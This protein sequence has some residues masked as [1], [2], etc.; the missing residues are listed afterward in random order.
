M[1]DDE[2]RGRQLKLRL[3]GTFI[4]LDDHEEFHSPRAH[5]EPR[6]AVT[7]S[8]TIFETE[9]RY[10]EQ[11]DPAAQRISRQTSSKAGSEGGISCHHPSAPSQSGS[12]ESPCEPYGATE[13]WHSPDQY[14]EVYV[15]PGSSP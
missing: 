3:R 2:S 6:S 12:G 11:L 14:G 4:D 15:S 7:K 9:Q 1:A 8:E 5:S 13:R 10:V